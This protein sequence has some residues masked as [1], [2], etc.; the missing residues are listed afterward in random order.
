MMSTEYYR[1][2]CLLASCV[3]WSVSCTLSSNKVTSA[4]SAESA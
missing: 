1:D 2:A 3:S 4:E